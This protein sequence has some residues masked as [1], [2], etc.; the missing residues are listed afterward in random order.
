MQNTNCPLC[1]RKVSI[2][3]LNNSGKCNDCTSRVLMENLLSS[4][5]LNEIFT[6][7]WKNKY[8]SEYAR[9]INN[10]KYGCLWKYRALIDFR[11]ILKNQDSNNFSE[12]KLEEAYYQISSY[13]SPRN[14]ETIQ[15]FLFSKGKIQFDKPLFSWANTHLK[16]SYYY[17]PSILEYYF[18]ESKCAD[19]GKAIRKQ[20]HRFCDVC[21]G[22]RSLVKF[23]EKV[24]LERMFKNK[25]IS[26]LFKSFLN[27]LFDSRLSH[28]YIDSISDIEILIF[29]QLDSDVDNSPTTKILS[30]THNILQ[31]IIS[32]QWIARVFEEL[33][34]YSFS[35]TKRKLIIPALGHFVG[36]LEKEKLIIKGTFSPEINIT[37][38][39]ITVS[40]NRVTTY[41]KIT[42]KIQDMPK[43][44]Q[45]LLEY[46]LEIE[47]ER[48]QALERKNATKS[49]SW[50][51]IEGEFTVFFSLIKWLII[52][53]SVF[54]WTLVSQD[55]INRYLL[56]FGNNQNRDIQK[57]KLYNF[58]EFGRKNRFLIQNPILPFKARDYYI[59]DRA[60]TRTNH[61][62]L[63]ASIKQTSKSNPTDSLLT[64]LCYFHVLSSKQIR[65]IKIS[66]IDLFRQC[67]HIKGRAP[68]YLNELVIQYL[69]NHLKIID[70]DR[71]H[72][73]TS[74]L[75][76]TVQK[77]SAL[78]V[79]NKWI[80]RHVKAV[81]DKTP[82]M[83]RKAG[84][85][86]CAEKFGPQFL[87]DC[88]GISLS[89]TGRFGNPD[90]WII[91]DILAEE[92]TNSE[93][94]M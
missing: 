75:F 40:M 77:G 34:V 33:P 17:L 49:L 38:E 13:K 3:T 85:Q 25:N 72:Y 92:L 24:E 30:F 18:D 58:F 91:E 2:N 42:K 78:Q 20:T 5:N 71:K 86:Y 53:E 10:S 63:F 59:I 52:N 70:Y 73:D 39:S 41:Q 54:D 79:S 46:Y 67:I 44:F 69:N 48:N 74:Y 14:L 80:N 87:H 84:L 62:E 56:N 4:A 94:D 83:L 43:G 23:C 7:G 16:N 45:A 35:K 60:F 32:P 89:H 90:D 93:V 50:K 27:F 31:E 12:K 82:S 66:D 36:F 61:K 22:R 64:S 26:N 76:F 81:Y 8:I 15:I 29:Q 47:K 11:K 19:C 88:F 57:R 51:S 37:E 21:M 28:S 65:E 9:F 6:E 1:G 68:A 55:M